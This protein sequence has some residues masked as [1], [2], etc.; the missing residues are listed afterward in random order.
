MQVGWLAIWV[1]GFFFGF[2]FLGT[3]SG[4]STLLY[5]TVLLA[6]RRFQDM[7]V[8]GVVRVSGF[9]LPYGKVDTMSPCTL[10]G[11][12]KRVS[13]FSMLGSPPTSLS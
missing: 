11:F 2:P 13:C 4:Y 10:Q 3:D 1:R 6:K 9:R 12:E 8:K 5:S 7:R